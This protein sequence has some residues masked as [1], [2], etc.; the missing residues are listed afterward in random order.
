MVRVPRNPGPYAHF[1]GQGPEILTPSWEKE[2]LLFVL[3]RQGKKEQDPDKELR[4]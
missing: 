2:A 1:R 3:K 4:L